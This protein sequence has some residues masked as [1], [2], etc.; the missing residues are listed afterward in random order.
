MCSHTYNPIHLLMVSTIY[1]LC[2][3]T[4]YAILSFNTFTTDNGNYDFSH[5]YEPLSVHPTDDFNDLIAWLWYE[6]II[7]AIFVVHNG[8][9]RVFPMWV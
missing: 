8:R 3:Y 2:M 5:P 9:K 7:M 1:K 6:D 4:L